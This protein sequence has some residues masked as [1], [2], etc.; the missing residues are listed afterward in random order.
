MGRQKLTPLD[1]I[2]SGKFDT[3]KKQI[4][5]AWHPQHDV[6]ALAASDNLYL[7]AGLEPEPALPEE[8]SRDDTTHISISDNSIVRSETVTSINS[9]MTEHKFS[10]YS[11][12][13]TSNHSGD[14]DGAAIA[15][16]PQENNNS[17]I[18][19]EDGSGDHQI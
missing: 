1:D 11:G 12:S 10:L 13:P 8:H 9:T 3:V 15:A 7:F 5:S 18:A 17:I 19:T 6:I 14:G 4:H 2:E 16:V